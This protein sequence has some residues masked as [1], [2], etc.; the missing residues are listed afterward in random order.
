MKKI[1]KASIA[2]GMLFAAGCVSNPYSATMKSLD[3]Q[4]GILDQHQEYVQ[5]DPGLTQEQKDRR[6]RENAA[7]RL[8]CERATAGDK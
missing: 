6:I 4:G 8:V 7:V 5:A 3:A 2:A 1:V